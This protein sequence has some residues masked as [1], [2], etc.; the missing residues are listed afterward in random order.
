MPYFP[1]DQRCCIAIYFLLE[2][3]EAQKNQELNKIYK[4]QKAPEIYK[5]HKT[6]PHRYINSKSLLRKESLISQAA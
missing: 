3:S 1:G 6:P 4:A 2:R 5:I